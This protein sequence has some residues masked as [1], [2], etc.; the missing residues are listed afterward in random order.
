MRRPVPNGNWFGDFLGPDVVSKAPYGNETSGEPAPL[1]TYVDSLG[2]HFWRE[3]GDPGSEQLLADVAPSKMPIRN[4]RGAR[5]VIYPL[6]VG[7]IDQVHYRDFDTGVVEQLTFDAG[8]K[9]ETWMWRAPEFDNE[10]VF[11]TLVDDVELRVYRKLADPGTGALRWTPVSWV[12]A[13]ANSTIASPEP[14]TFNARSYVF[15]AMTINPH[16]FHSS[17]WISNIDAAMSDLPANHRQPG[18]CAFVLNPGTITNRGPMI[19][20]NRFK[21][22]GFVPKACVQI[23]CS[24][25][26]YRADPGSLP[27]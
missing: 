4:V 21:P 19:Y 24:E 9:Q 22:K 23:S 13:P 16:N 1:L 25:G 15:M 8:M 2:N 17:I 20:Y 12:P 10:L 3:L 5:A 7:G 27:Q 14:F 11:M 6:P 18:S 26:V